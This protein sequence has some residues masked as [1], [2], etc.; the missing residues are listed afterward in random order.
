MDPDQDVQKQDAEQT[1]S[2]TDP[3]LVTTLRELGDEY[4]ALGVALAAADMTD[5][6]V[7]VQCLI[8]EQAEEQT[9]LDADLCGAA[10]PWNGL[11]RCTR[12]EG[13]LGVH[14]STSAA[15]IHLTWGH[16][17]TH[18]LICGAVDPV[19][20]RRRCIRPQHH[21]GVHSDENGA[22]WNRGLNRA[23]DFGPSTVQ[24]EDETRQP[25]QE[26]L[27]GLATTEELMRE[28]I[29]RFT[30]KFTIHD[31]IGGVEKALVLAEMLGSLSSTEREYRTVDKRQS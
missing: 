5:V 15:G 30:A 25:P 20:G 4:G 28:L 12:P 7:L 17:L 22:V 2:R 14:V 9:T 19:S 29:V 13:H 18:Q 27:L 1:P 16:Q 6:R 8:H 10:D 24:K 31:V 3:D 11:H 23:T 26:P 21:P